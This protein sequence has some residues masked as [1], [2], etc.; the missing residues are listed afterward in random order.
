MKQVFKNS[1]A[2]IFAFTSIHCTANDKIDNYFKENKFIEVKKEIN[3]TVMSIDPR[4]EFFQ[5]F[6]MVGG[7]T[8]NNPADMDYKMDVLNYFKEYC[9]HPSFAYARTHFVELFNSIDAPY[10]FL[11]SLNNDFTLRADLINNEWQNRPEVD[12]M[13]EAFRKFLVET[14][15]VEFFNSQVDFYNLVLGNALYTLNDFDEKNR[16]LDYHGIK[17]KDDYKFSLV[18]NF[19]GKGNFGFRVSSNSATEFYATVS[20]LGNGEVP[21]VTKM[22]VSNLIWHEF[23]HSFTNPLVDKYWDELEQL[24]SLY[25]PIKASMAGQAYRSWKTTLYEHMTRALTCRMGANK[26]GEDY[27]AINFERNEMGKKFI[28]TQTLIEAVKEYENSRDK[29]PTFESF[30]PQMVKALSNLTEAQIAG[31][32]KTVQQI[33][34][35]NVEHI[36]LLGKFH[37]SENKLVI[38]STNEQDTAAD[39]RLQTY[40][41]N[42]FPDYEYMADTTAL[43]TDLRNNNLWVI[44]TPTGNKFLEKYLSLLPSKIEKDYVVVGDK[45]EGSGYA[46]FS[47]W[48]NPFNTENVMNVFVGQNPDNLVNFHFVPRGGTN[49]ILTKNIVV[50][51]SLDYKR[52]NQIWGCY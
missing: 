28:Y 15:F 10:P 42:M 39:K 27:A 3:G 50:L 34:E 9:E 1:L 22:E 51:K 41:R 7:N 31:L 37:F 30:M 14:D 13:L 21:Y 20:P 12:A 8:N 17:N 24:E 4:I 11:Y 18:I 25:Q 43:K 32:L 5:I 26:Y 49:Y 40:V 23:G 33:R 44:G 29:Y 47:A 6:C 36:P 48:V 46:F 16:M 2:I 52:Y 45:Y 35:P 19:L 38:Y